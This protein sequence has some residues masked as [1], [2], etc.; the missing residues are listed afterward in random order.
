MFSICLSGRA[1]QSPTNYFFLTDTLRFLL[2]RHR[3]LSLGRWASVWLNSRSTR[4]FFS[5]TIGL[6]PLDS[7]Q[8]RSPAKITPSQSELA[9]SEDH[10]RDPA[11][12]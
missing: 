7:G 1:A 8:G 3:T 11:R 6:G 10:L 12:L 9:Y 2:Q 5:A 4:V